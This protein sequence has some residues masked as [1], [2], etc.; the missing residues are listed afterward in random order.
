MSVKIELELVSGG[1]RALEM[2]PP[3]PGPTGYFVFMRHAS[4]QSIW[5]LLNK[6]LAAAAQP[7]CR[8]A[9]QLHK[10]GF[11]EP[12]VS[13]DSMR[14]WL[15]KDGYAFGN[16]SHV[17]SLS[18]DLDQAGRR[19][20]LFV[21]DPREIVAELHAES[22]SAPI[23]EFLKSPPV[24]IFLRQCQSFVAFHRAREHVTVI[25]VEDHKF[26]WR[27]LALDLIGAFKLK[28]EGGTL[29]R[30]IGITPL[31]SQAEPQSSYRRRF[32]QASRSAL[33]ALL[34]ETLAHFGYP[35][36]ESP[37]P[38]FLDHL[39]E[40]LT[41]VAG[42]P[43]PADVEAPES[44]KADESPAAARI[45]EA[46]SAEI[47]RRRPASLVEPDPQLNWRLRANGAREITVLGRRVLTQADAYG[48]RPVLG[49][50]ERGEKTLAVYGCS[51]TFGLALPYEETFCSNLQAMF[52]DWRVENYGTGGYGG[53]QNLIQLRRN[54]RWSGAD[55]VTF[56]VLRDHLLRNVA[57]ISFRR[58]LMAGGQGHTGPQRSYRVSLRQASEMGPRRYRSYRPGAGRPVSLSCLPRGL[59]PR[60]RPRDGERRTV[61]PHLPARKHRSG[62]S[63]SD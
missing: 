48:C 18:I 36:H 27:K 40:F 53:T 50:P 1:R 26:G 56:C 43:S 9:P 35:P 17:D 8:V 31:I 6:L 32:D 57:D 45:P 44:P 30:I 59:S 19:T 11:R 28:V 22:P 33:E 63:P 5:P 13:P 58:T 38:V 62:I 39:G 37:S 60:P 25:R 16:L 4:E 29:Q 14:N 12:D 7:V 61:L 47:E 3:G 54:S 20:F 24:K 52:P 46:A 55:Y 51:F 10:A 34:A 41:A 21:R 15:L 49:Q 42:W 2:P 23:P